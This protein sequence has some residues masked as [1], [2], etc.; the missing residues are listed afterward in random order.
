[1]EG[2]LPEELDTIEGLKTSLE[3]EGKRFGRYKRAAW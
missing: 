1:M 3:G 2:N